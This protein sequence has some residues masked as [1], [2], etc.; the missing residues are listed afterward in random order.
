MNAAEGTKRQTIVVAG[1]G[2]AG[3]MVAAAFARFLSKGFRIRL[4]ESEEIGTVGV[5]EATIPHIRLFNQALGFDEDEFIR[6]T[7]ATFKLGIEFVGWLRPGERY[8]HAFGDVG[9]DSGLLPFHHSWLRASREGVARPLGDYSLNNVAALAGRMQRG[10]ARTSKMLPEMPY[11]FHFDAGLYARFLRQFAERRGVERTEGRISGVERDPDSGDVAA[12]VLADGERVRGNLFIDCTGFRAL[13][14]EGALGAGYEDWSKWL[15]CD[16]AMAVPSGRA[17]AF[18][19]YTRASAHGAGW[20]WR[21]PLQHRTGNGIVYSS[22][23]LSDDEAAARLVENL[24]S[25]PLADPRPLRFTG[26][27][28]REMWKGNVIA[29][30]L[31]AGFMEPLE[32]T[33]IHLIQTAIS[34]IL[35]FLPGA[36]PAQAER[37]EFNRQ[38]RFEYE[39]IRDFL[40]LH[41]RANGRDEPFWREMREVPM[42]ASLAA[43]FALWEGNGHIAR[44]HDELF[45]E[46]AWLQVFVG[47]GVMPEG[48]H[49]VADLPTKAELAEYF[50]LMAKLVR[51]EVD[52]M[53]SHEEFVARHCAA[54]AGEEAIGATA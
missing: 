12:L 39:R 6:A 34:R 24:D 54:A 37:D 4:V 7:Q 35:K 28:R 3:W 11:A 17:A 42:P 8:M 9:R 16:R 33:S 23:H 18:T 13:L 36:H 48:N 53:P 15:P 40:I 21:I 5:G 29:V 19:P 30:G 31:A 47:Q 26:G 49:P 27:M 22:R 38:S 51:R 52:Q 50:D 14:I 41:Y 32:S 2:T 44:E 46:V 10:S 20:Q 1:G 25:P 43:K 45:A